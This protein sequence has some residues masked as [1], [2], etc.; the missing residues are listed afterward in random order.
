MPACLTIL[1]GIMALSQAAQESELRVD[2]AAGVVIVP[3]VVAKQGKYDVLKGAIEYVLVS[4]EGKDYETL[5]ITEARPEDVHAALLDAGLEPGA[6][7]RA[8]GAPEGPPVRILIEYD[9]GGKSVRRPAEEFVLHAKTGK[10]LETLPW[11]FTGSVKAFDPETKKEVFQCTLTKS[12]VGLHFTDPASLLQNARPE[13][14]KENIYKARADELPPA[15][16]PVKVIFEQVRSQVPAG[17]RRVRA[18]ISG[19]I[20]GVGFE[21]FAQRRAR[22]LGLT[23]RL[24]KS[25]E[26]R[27]EALIEGPD[28]GV[29]RLLDELRS[30]PRAAKVEK[31]ETQEEPARGDRKDFRLEP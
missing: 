12:L 23:G 11:T 29:A 25:G 30:R 14:A 21:V 19:R 16:T 3:A 8:G 26:A 6:P 28:E 7:A 24:R 4:R 31:I 17:T 15:D 22:S 20:E 2:R 13:A 10:P 27:M 18:V 5:F 9:R 1:I